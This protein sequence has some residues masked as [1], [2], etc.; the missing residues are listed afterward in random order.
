MAEKKNQHFVP[1]VH[2]RQFSTDARQ[3][4]IDIWLPKHDK[5]INGASINDQ[6]SKPYFYGSDLKIENSFN[7]PEGVFGNIVKKLDENRNPSKGELS[8]LLFLWLLQHVRSEKAIRD[9]LLSITMITDKIRIGQEDN[10]ELDRFIGDPLDV[11][12]AAD[13][14]LADLG[15]YYH[16][17]SDL[18]CILLINDTKQGFIASDNPAVS[19]NKLILK[20]FMNYR[21]WG[22]SSAG[23]YLYMP[24]SPKIG[25]F[26]Y[27]RHV[28]D[29]KGRSGLNCRLK[30]DDVHDL[31][32]LLYLFS[33]NVVVL[34]PG[35][36]QKEVVRNLQSFDFAKPDG[37][38]RVNTAVEEKRGV[39]EGY[40][41]FVQAS[42]E[43]FGKSES[44]LI[45]IES[46]PPVVPRHFRKLIIRQIPRYIDT[47]SGAGLKRWGPLIKG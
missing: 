21:N 14:A 23:F 30:V 45:H 47:Q 35:C 37:L 40:R 2:L 42:D 4:Q 29:L 46:V 22:I 20:R 12:E 8:N 33:D 26:A 13:M 27:D 7:T 36:D 3:K 15:Y 32:K 1:K 17:I 39:G 11:R 28:Y 6:C 9:H 18:K 24:L 34:P 10:E 5:F 16:C 25:F 43:N 38:V 31:N 41:K 19:S 44:S